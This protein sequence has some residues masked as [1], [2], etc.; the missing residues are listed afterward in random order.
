MSKYIKNVVMQNRRGEP[1]EWTYPN[2]TI[3]EGVPPQLYVPDTKPNMTVRQLFIL[4]CERFTSDDMGRHRVITRLENYLL[5]EEE[6]NKDSG[7]LTVDDDWYAKI[8]EFAK[9]WLPKAYIRNADTLYD[10]IEEL[11]K[12]GKPKAEP[13]VEEVED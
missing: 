8:M 13:E 12:D 5:D 4:M 7:Y 6:S 11:A 9:L 1:M 10:R 2:Q 3:P